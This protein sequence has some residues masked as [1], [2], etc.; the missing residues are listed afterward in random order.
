M[1]TST[2]CSTNCK[3]NQNFGK[4]LLDKKVKINKS[5]WLTFVLN[6]MIN[7]FY[8]AANVNIDE[9]K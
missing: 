8:N 7:S 4:R 9:D 5:H 3:Q 1:E 6:G 2:F